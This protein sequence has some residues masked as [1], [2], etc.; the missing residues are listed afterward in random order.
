M[1]YWSS[2]RILAEVRSRGISLS[3]L[4]VQHGLKP[5]TLGSALQKPNSRAEEIIAGFL[6][7]P[8]HHLWPERYLS[9]G[10]RRRPQ[11]KANYRPRRRFHKPFEKVA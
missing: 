11:P 9:T 4:G 2:H 1:E 6:G 10:Q 3:R 8:A 5:Q 7:V